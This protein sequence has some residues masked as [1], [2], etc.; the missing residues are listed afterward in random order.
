M[1]RLR[2][3]RRYVVPALVFTL[4]FA[5]SI[6]ALHGLYLAR[7]FAYH[8]MGLINDFL[9]NTTRHWPPFWVT[10]TGTSHLRMHFTPTLLLVA[11]LYRV[12][13]SPF[14]LLV[15][16]ATALFVGLWLL[17]LLTRSAIQCDQESRRWMRLLSDVCLPLV[18]CGNIYCRSV[19][20]S[21]H[22]E[23]PYVLFA[24]ATLFA[25][26]RGAR[27]AVVLALWLLTL[28]ART[29]AGFFMAFQVL[30]VAFLPA[31]MLPVDRRRLRQRVAVLGLLSFLF[32]AVA[33]TWIMPALGALPA[34]HVRR[35]W[36]E[37]GD[38]WAEVGLRVAASPLWLA[39]RVAHSGFVPLNASLGFV[40]ILNPPIFALSN[41]PGTL[42]YI[43]NAPDKRALAHYNS[44]LLLPGLF[45]GLAAAL[46]CIHSLAQRRRQLRH[47][48]AAALA[49]LVLLTL[50]TWPATA[51]NGPPLAPQAGAVDPRLLAT[52][53]DQLSHCSDVRS[54]AT[55][56][57]N[58]VF[59]PN[60]YQKYLLKHFPMADAVIV[61]ADGAPFP[62]DDAHWEHIRDRVQE[63]GIFEALQGEP[64]YSVWVR[65]GVTCPRD[66]QR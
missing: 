65:E 27:L 20:V 33:A 17:F 35:F 66:L 62:G 46:H 60:R 2:L 12:V 16:N 64:G 26:I 21:A 31:A 5:Y 50:R 59:V 37:L 18:L 51:A 3:S 57:R 36:G 58:V 10:H 22:Y 63:S 19:L 49:I 7:T 38:T 32:T 39:A 43:S 8:D 34:G 11:P 54:V 56:F 25:L 9:G 61:T 48:V 6:V 45:L 1:R 30:C 29:D 14:L 52:L 13:D 55:D 24:S 41:L 40:T 42:F 44:A 47:A 15:W 53:S 4:L 23:T 28:G